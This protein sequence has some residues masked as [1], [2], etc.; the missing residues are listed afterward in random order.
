MAERNTGASQLRKGVV[1]L[2]V[3]GLLNKEA[4][5]GSQLV[6]ELATQP[7]LAITAGTVYPLLAR[8]SKGDLVST[9]W[10]ESPSGPPRKYYALTP[11]GRTR[12]GTLAAEF[13][14]ITD[15]MNSL[16]G[17]VK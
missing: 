9:H 12:Q 6:A 16:F 15:A 17:G 8:L 7:A 3:L 11:A 2:A 13:H 1:E 4:K 5:Y 14:A 10:Q